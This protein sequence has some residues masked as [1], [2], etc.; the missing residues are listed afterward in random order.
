MKLRNCTQNFEFGAERSF[1][2]SRQERMYFLPVRFV[3]LGYLLEEFI[4]LRRCK[5]DLIQV[6]ETLAVLRW[7]VVLELGLDCIRPQKSV[8]DE[9]TRQPKKQWF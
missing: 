2:T 1:P 9:R 8:S 6:L 4:I 5:A 7:V 3:Q